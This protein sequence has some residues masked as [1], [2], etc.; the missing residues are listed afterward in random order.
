MKVTLKNCPFC[1][2]I[3][4]QIS[5]SKFSPDLWKATLLCFKCEIAAFS[6]G[7][8]EDEAVERIARRW[9]ARYKEPEMKITEEMPDDEDIEPTEGR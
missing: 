4:L 1:G 6:F 7:L 9:N 5:V 2:G 3:T 8:S